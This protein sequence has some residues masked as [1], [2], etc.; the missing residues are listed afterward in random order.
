MYYVSNF[1][2]SVFFHF[3]QSISIYFYIEEYL[4]QPLLVFHFNPWETRHLTQFKL[5][6]KITLL[7][8][9]SI[10]NNNNLW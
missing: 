2:Y 1:I 10:D 5:Q 4:K 8:Q 9:H 7:V 3:Y 6:I